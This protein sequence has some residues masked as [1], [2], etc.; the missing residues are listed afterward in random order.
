[1]VEYTETQ[2][3]EAKNLIDRVLNELDGQHFTLQDINKTTGAHIPKRGGS[4][5]RFHY[6]QTHLN[7]L[8]ET[9][10]IAKNEDGSY[11]VCRETVDPCAWELLDE[12]IREELLQPFL[13]S[14]E[15]ED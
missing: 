10:S 13:H 14:A 1:M 9:G 2:V 12:D 8:E 11:Y 15:Y 6:T 5:G 7:Y 4:L 3:E